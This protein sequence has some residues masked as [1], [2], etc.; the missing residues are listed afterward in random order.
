MLSLKYALTKE[1]YVN[2]Y[3][4]VMWDAPEKKK[5]KLKYYFRQIAFNIG[6]ITFIY[7]TGILSVGKIFLYA[8]FGIFLL[9][10][11]SNLLFARTKIKKQAE[12]V[13]AN[14]KNH[15]IFLDTSLQITDIGIALKDELSE[16]SFVWK[17]FVKKAEHENYYFLFTSALQAIIIPKR[18]FKTDEKIQFEKLLSQHLSLDA[19][20]GDLI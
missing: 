10:V 14:E 5:A 11:A 8:Y 12:K 16:S 1:D 13:T 7:F 6:I 20:I 18:I 17:A 3:C 2:Y 19:E 15:S 4:Y 9:S